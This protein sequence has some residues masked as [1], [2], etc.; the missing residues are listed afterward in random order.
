M[1]EDIEP[2][3]ATWSLYLA[4]F[5]HSSGLPQ[6]IL[7]CH[8]GETK[9]GAHHHQMCTARGPDSVDLFHDLGYERL[10]VSALQIPIIFLCKMQDQI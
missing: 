9:F 3:H 5:A 1:V 4:L 6:N 8:E 10:S 2:F 7:H